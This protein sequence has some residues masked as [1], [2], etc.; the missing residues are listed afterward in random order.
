MACGAH[1][2]GSWLFSSRPGQISS[3]ANRYE[4]SAAASPAIFTI[5]GRDISR[6]ISGK[7]IPGNPSVTV[8]NMPG[9]GSVIAANYV[10]NVAKPDGLTL[11]SLNPGIYMDQLIGRKEVQFDWAKFNWLGTPEQTE[12]VFFFRGDS[13]YKTIDDLRK[14]NEPPRCG[15]TGTASTTYHIPKLLEEVFGVKFTIITGYQGAA[16]IDVALERGELQCRLITI[17][18][19]FGREP[20]ISWFK[21]GFTRPFVQTGRKRDPQLPETPTVYDLMD[22]YKSRRCRPPPCHPGHGA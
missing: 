22:R 9:A 18:A 2:L 10:Y 4:S 1:A 17:A 13:P 12:S 21:K 8:Q 3:K 20:H 5:F 7:H 16:D 19:F 14:A 15:S 11:G 6:P